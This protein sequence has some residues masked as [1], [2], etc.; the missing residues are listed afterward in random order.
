MAV[1]TRLSGSGRG[2]LER[3]GRELLVNGGLVVIVIASGSMR[4]MLINL[5]KWGEKVAVEGTGLAYWRDS[6]QSGN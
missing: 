4:S 3:V 1:G 5:K 2:L 6:R